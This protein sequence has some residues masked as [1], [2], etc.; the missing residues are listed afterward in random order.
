L[1]RCYTLPSFLPVARYVRRVDYKLL[2][3]WALISII[4]EKRRMWPRKNVMT[5][6]LIPF[7]NLSTRIVYSSI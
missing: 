5:L 2:V 1:I 3:T 4:A 7:T 6:T